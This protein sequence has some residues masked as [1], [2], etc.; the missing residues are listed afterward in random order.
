MATKTDF[1]Q[2][3]L[4]GLSEFTNAWGDVLN[5]N[6]EI[7]DDWVA[8]LFESLVGSSSTSTWA[9][10]RGSM[11]SLADRLAISINND[12]TL[13]TSSS[14]QILALALSLLYGAQADP[15][16]R[17]D[18]SDLE[19]YGARSPAYT[20]RNTLLPTASG[21]L[22]DGIAQRVA[23]P[24]LSSTSPLGAA[25]RFAQGM[26]VG[27][28]SVLA[29]AGTA[30]IV[31]QGVSIGDHT[32]WC[33]FSIDGYTFRVRESIVLDYGNLSP[34]NGQRVYLFVDRYDYND[35][36]YKYRGSTDSASPMAKDL[37]T[38]QNGTDGTIGAGA[39]VFTSPSA[40]FQSAKLGLPLPG[41]LLVISSGAAAGTYGIA[42]VDSDTQV[43]ILGGFRAINLSGLTWSIQ[44]RGAPNIGAM[45]VGSPTDLPPYQTGRAYIGTCLHASSGNPSSIVTFCKG[46]VY[47]ST[48]LDASTLI[49]GTPMS[50]THNLGDYPREVTILV[51]TSPTSEAFQPI[52]ER[53]VVTDAS[54]P[55][56]ATLYVPSVRWS[57]TAYVGT[58]RLKNVS[59]TPSKPS[60]LFTDG[61]GTDQTSGWIRV[62]VRR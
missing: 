52:V 39:T 42:S 7:I 34:T 20:G 47:D 32:T 27:S 25:G 4:P 51:A 16:T 62:I 46:G 50:F 57:S 9:G 13:D 56:S 35:A 1:L 5:Q 6:N 59:T 22:D 21:V 60:A 41:D 38:L 37:R 19:L 44:D 30:R 31:F 12:G 58:L 11:D 26:V 2:L 43:T 40:H 28:Q 24:F 55:T 49:G 36:Q 53:S 48:W 33:I 10:L 61:S 17:L 14:P 8:D 45:I 54:G 29:G 23:D 15:R 18:Q 3:T